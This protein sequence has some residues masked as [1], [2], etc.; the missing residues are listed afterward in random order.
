LKVKY[1]EAPVVIDQFT[2]NP[3]GRWIASVRHMAGYEPIGIKLINQVSYR[4]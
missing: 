4:K 1:L 2:F 3:D